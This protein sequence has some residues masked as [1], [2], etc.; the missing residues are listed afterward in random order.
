MTFLLDIKIIREVIGES[1]NELLYSVPYY[2]ETNTIEEFFSQL[3]HYV[4]NKSPQTYQD[5]HKTISNII[6]SNIK[7]KHF[8]L[9]DW[10]NFIYLPIFSTFLRHKLT[11]LL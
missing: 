8:F 3:K 5:I 11:D 10:C 7:P 6:D 4:K 1:K 9:F 2:L